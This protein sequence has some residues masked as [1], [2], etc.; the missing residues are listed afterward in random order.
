VLEEVAGLDL[1]RAKELAETR[2]FIGPDPMR[3]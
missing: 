3:S 1:R 2:T